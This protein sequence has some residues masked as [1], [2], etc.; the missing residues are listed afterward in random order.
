[1]GKK[2]EETSEDVIADW[3]DKIQ[4]DAVKNIIDAF[5]EGYQLGKQ[6]AREIYGVGHE[7]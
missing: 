5:N 2:Q 6:H 4:Q 1:M 7:D 3:L